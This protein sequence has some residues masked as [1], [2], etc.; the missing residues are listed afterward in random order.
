MAP[1]LLHSSGE[2]KL[3]A[4]P[5]Q[6]WREMSSLINVGTVAETSCTYPE[7]DSNVIDLGSTIPEPEAPCHRKKQ[8]RA[9]R[10]QQNQRDAH[11][12]YKVTERI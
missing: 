11:Q 10:R 8:A 5:L 12:C 1:L 2:F 4:E 7:M 9:R 6:R 3:D